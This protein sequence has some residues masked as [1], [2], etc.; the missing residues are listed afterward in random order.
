MGGRSHL[1]HTSLWTPQSAPLLFLFPSVGTIVA[2]GG[3][4]PCVSV[5]HR[6]L[7]TAVSIQGAEGVLGGSLGPTRGPPALSRSPVSASP[8]CHDVV[9]RT[10]DPKAPT[11]EACSRPVPEVKSEIKVR[12]RLDPSEASLPGLQP[13]AFSLPSV[14]YCPLLRTPGAPMLRTSF[15]IFITSLKALSPNTVLFGDTGG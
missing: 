7:L 3:S 15:F 14:S 11:T 12:A 5:G 6:S 2:A 1:D 8:G 4:S 13:E 10:T 9:E